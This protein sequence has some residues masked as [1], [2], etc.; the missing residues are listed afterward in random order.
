MWPQGCRLQYCLASELKMKY[1][2]VF[3]GVGKLKDFKLNLHVDLNV[4]PVAQKLRRVLFALHEKVSAKID[5]LLREDIMDRVEGPTMWAS[6]VVVA[7]KLS[8]EIRFC[9][10]LRCTNRA[11]VRERLPIATV[12]EVLEELNGSTLS[13]FQDWA[14]AGD[15]TR[16]SYM[17]ILGTLLFLL[18]MKASSGTK[19]SV[20]V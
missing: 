1:P 16:H 13:C 11:I 19:G 8:R 5:E 18:P 7:P 6:P 12:D 9:N 2:K 15:F 14:F 3:Q 4:P 17:Q 10:N 20:L